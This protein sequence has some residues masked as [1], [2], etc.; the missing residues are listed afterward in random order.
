MKTQVTNNTN[1]IEALERQFTT[2]DNK[3]DAFDARLTSAEGNIV[4]LTT[5]V[6]K[7]ESDITDIK[8]K[9][10]AQDEKF[11]ELNSKI[12]SLTA[13]V[14]DL[15][16][17]DVAGLLSEIEKIKKVT[18]YETYT[19]TKN[20]SVRLDEIE[21][22]VDDNATEINTIENNMIG[23]KESPVEGS[24]WHE[25]NNIIDAGMF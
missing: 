16:G 15:V 8:G 21:G 12:E 25:L 10:S 7:T 11:A 22:N 2:L 13:L 24:I 19:N 17:G 4:N 9:L 5:R 18:G 1:N 6:A 14:Q 23:S 20:M 3:I